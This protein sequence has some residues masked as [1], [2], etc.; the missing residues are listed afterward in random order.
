MKMARDFSYYI[1]YARNFSYF[2]VYVHCTVVEW[3]E[4]LGYGAES[5]QKVGVRGWASP[6]DDRKT[7][8]V[9]PVVNGY[10]F[11]NQGKLR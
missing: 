10:Y 4:S 5:R 11:S 1:V 9:N 2:I 6:C 7:L 8:F 3:L